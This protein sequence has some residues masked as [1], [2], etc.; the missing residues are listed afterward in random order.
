VRQTRLLDASE[1]EAAGRLLARAFIDDPGAAI[2]EPDPGRRAAVNRTLFE[3]DVDSALGAVWGCL[4]DQT[5]LGVSIWLDPDVVP[6]PP[7]ELRL[8]QLRARLGDRRV[9][10]WLEMLDGFERVRRGAAAGPHWFLALLGTDP[11]AQGSGVGAALLQIGHAAA[12][13]VGLPCLLETFTDSN[14]AYYQRRGYRVVLSRTI[15][16][17]PIHAMARQPGGAA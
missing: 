4:D 8:A 2:I 13:H 14:V 6:E 12:D 15:A 16:G 1:V 11:T 3:F 9:D 10:R 7:D 5:L 17:E